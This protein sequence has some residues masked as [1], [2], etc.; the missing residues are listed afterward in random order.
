AL[1]TTSAPSPDGDNVTATSNVP[2]SPSASARVADSIKL[3]AQA[4]PASEPVPPSVSTEPLSVSVVLSSG[5]VVVLPSLPLADVSLV[6]PA[7]DVPAS[8]FD[9]V[10][11]PASEAAAS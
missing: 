11:S 5:A 3:T 9:G 1:Q 8:S 7:V 2:K 4:L 6:S 10:V